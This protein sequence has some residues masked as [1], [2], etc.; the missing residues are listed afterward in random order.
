MTMSEQVKKQVKHLTRLWK[1]SKTPPV[2][3][4]L[5]AHPPSLFFSL[6]S[7]SS[8]DFGPDR[9]RKM[10]QDKLLLLLFY[11]AFM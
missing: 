5:P 10:E 6:A 7:S 8:L 4:H 1:H 2:M 3:F 11:F 9:D